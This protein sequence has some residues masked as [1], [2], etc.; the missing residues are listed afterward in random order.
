MFNKDTGNKIN[1][2]KGSSK[3]RLSLLALRA[4]I[5]QESLVDM[6]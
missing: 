4:L 2:A 5:R 6:K 3:L 1:T